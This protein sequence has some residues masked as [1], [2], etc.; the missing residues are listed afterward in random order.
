[1]GA[2]EKTIHMPASILIILMLSSND[3][4]RLAFEEQQEV[5]NSR[6]G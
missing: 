1:M 2:I 3:A 4:T 6:N 5:L